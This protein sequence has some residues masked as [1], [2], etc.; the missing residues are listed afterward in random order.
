MQ[1]GSGK[2]EVMEHVILKNLEET[3]RLFFLLLS[4]YIAY[5][6]VTVLVCWDMWPM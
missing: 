2:M 6:L 1:L 5:K 3:K 4:P